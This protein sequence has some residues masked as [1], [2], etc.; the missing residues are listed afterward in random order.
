MRFAFV[1]L[2]ACGGELVESEQSFEPLV[3]DV[4]VRIEDG[5]ATLSVH[6]GLRGIE[7]ELE[8]SIPLPSAGAVDRFRFAVD[9]RWTDGELLDVDAAT[10]RYEVLSGLAGVHGH[11]IEGATAPALL[12]YE[13]N[14]N[15]LL[16]A[17]PLSPE[18]RIEF[19]YRIVLPTCHA[20][21]R[22]M[23]DYPFD[24]ED[25]P[26]FFGP[27]VMRDPTDDDD[28]AS[29]CDADAAILGSSR[30]VIETEPLEEM[31]ATYAVQSIGDRTAVRVALDLPE[32]LAPIPTAPA[33]V[34]LMDG[35]FSQD[36]PSLADQLAWAKA[37][38]A[39]VPDANV[40]VVV[41]R[42]EGERLFE[43]MVPA[44]E[45][46]DAVATLPQDKLRLG[47]G[48]FLDRGLA[49]AT[50]IL[51]GAGS[52][53]RIVV[54][55][56]LAMRSGFD[57][58]AVSDSLGRDV[59]HLVGRETSTGIDPSLAVDS[60]Q[61]LAQIP[62]TTGGVAAY[63][64]GDPTF[65]GAIEAIEELVRPIRLDEVELIGLDDVTFGYT[66]GR[67]DRLRTTALLD[68]RAPDS[69]AIRGLLW[70]SPVKFEVARSRIIEGAMPAILIATAPGLT[71]EEGRAIANAGGV[72]SPYT[73]YLAE[74]GGVDPMDPPPAFGELHS[75]G[76]F[77][78]GTSCGC[79]GHCRLKI[80]DAFSDDW[81]RGSIDELARACSA[82]D[83]YVWIETTEDEIA[84][85][86]VE[87]NG[88][89]CLVEAIWSLRL[90]EEYKV[91]SRRTLAV[92]RVRCD[93]G[94]CT[95]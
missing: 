7:G 50:Q 26:T 66:V 12:S 92:D 45:F 35:S 72:V 52:E 84:D 27:G 87:G 9:D 38:L 73:S 69:I 81:L 60:S 48:S 19:E 6:R 28:F 47:N 40:E 82:V 25:P 32:E 44:R 77:G 65:D 14:G 57:V 18:N 8:H 30:V 16:R 37:Y 70:S 58:Q 2:T 10:D 55:S 1:F 86:S 3:H 15:L 39:W 78:F 64:Y 31:A 62:Q 53:T 5:V 68:T 54:T 61:E 11:A 33:V 88:A 17:H 20:N 85:V 59:V 94:S 91:Q 67:G 23:L 56:D 46:A 13:S 4:E 63:L 43:R 36:D 49:L 93:S 42:R 22:A 24:A 90:P 95:P 75:I 76:A 41:F 71:E 80:R 79:C 89:E 29:A 34:F 83:A 51:A 21:G 74:R